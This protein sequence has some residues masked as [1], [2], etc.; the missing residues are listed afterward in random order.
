MNICFVCWAQIYSCHWI[1]MKPDFLLFRKVRCHW[2][3]GEV[4]MPYH[5]PSWHR[6]MFP[7]KTEMPAR[8]S[9]RFSLL[10]HVSQKNC[11]QYT[12]PDWYGMGNQTDLLWSSGF[13]SSYV[14]WIVRPVLMCPCL[15]WNN[16][17]DLTTDS[18]QPYRRSWHIQGFLKCMQCSF[19]GTAWNLSDWYCL[20]SHAAVVC[21]H[22]SC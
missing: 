1:W 21:F 5:I 8:N 12:L 17:Y 13:S 2:P 4:C 7:G 22:I 16:M 9:E 18:L 3:W 6:C 11:L 14:C 15:G 20:L 10:C 19:S